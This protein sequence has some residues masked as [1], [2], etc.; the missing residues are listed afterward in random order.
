MIL[1]LSTASAL[2]SFIFY[3]RTTLIQIIDYL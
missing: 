2:F 3:P 1:E